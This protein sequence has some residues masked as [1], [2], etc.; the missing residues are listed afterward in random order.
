MLSAGERVRGVLG[1]SV[2]YVNMR[3]YIYASIMRVIATFKYV[4]GW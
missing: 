2:M 4:L 1:S 3:V